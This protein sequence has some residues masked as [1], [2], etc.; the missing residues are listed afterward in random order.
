MAKKPRKEPELSLTEIKRAS[1]A[2]L[3]DIAQWCGQIESLEAEAEEK[4]RSIH[5]Q[6][7]AWLVPLQ[8]RLQ[9]NIAWLKDTMKSNKNVLFDGTDVVNLAHGSLIH[10]KVDK[11]TIP[12]DAL[13]TCK[14]LEFTDVI[15][16]V[17]SLD[18]EAVEKWPDEKLILIGAQRKPKEEFSYDLKKAEKKND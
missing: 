11:V 13:A 18:R 5:A 15:K 10:S 16:T 12:R 2:A 7:S 14:A 9:R 1:D 8:E 4:I 3:A 6:Y 17:E